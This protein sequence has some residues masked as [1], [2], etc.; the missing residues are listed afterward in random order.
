MAWKKDYTV[1]AKCPTCE[2]VKTAEVFARRDEV[3]HKCW[4]INFCE[5][6]KKWHKNIDIRLTSEVKLQKERLVE[7]AIPS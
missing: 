4:R 6:C 7:N 2:N 1:T 5:F 3:S